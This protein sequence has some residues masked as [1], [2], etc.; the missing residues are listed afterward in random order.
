MAVSTRLCFWRSTPTRN[1]LLFQTIGEA[2]PA[3]GVGIFQTIFVFASQ[4][5]GMLFSRLVPFPRGPRHP[6]QFSAASGCADPV[7]T[8]SPQII[9][10]TNRV[11]SISP[12]RKSSDQSLRAAIISSPAENSQ[13]LCAGMMTGGKMTGALI[14]PARRGSAVALIGC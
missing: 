5:T 8:R 1:S 10:P 7:A 3:C 12:H 4:R 2:C 11:I 6:G 9:H 13:T 14:R